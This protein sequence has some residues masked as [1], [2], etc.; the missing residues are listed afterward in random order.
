MK[1]GNSQSARRTSIDRACRGEY[2]EAMNASKSRDVDRR[3]KEKVVSVGQSKSHGQNSVLQSQHHGIRRIRRTWSPF[4]IQSLL[5]PIPP[6]H[7]PS[8][9]SSSAP[10]TSTTT[11]HS[12]R[13]SASRSHNTLMASDPVALDGPNSR[14]STS[15]Q[16]MVMPVNGVKRS[17]THL[18]EGKYEDPRCAD[19]FLSFLDWGLTRRR[20]AL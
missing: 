20:A 5:L 18:D 12:P 15:G 2:T 10:S 17:F 14:P 11:F 9:S 19:L 16:H 3:L 13:T 6:L 8:T 4:N 1:G 7:L